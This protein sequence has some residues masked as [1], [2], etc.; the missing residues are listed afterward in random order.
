MRYDMQVKEEKI[1]E[2]FNRVIQYYP[3]NIRKSYWGNVD[4]FINLITDYEEKEDS[5]S[6]GCKNSAIIEFPKAIFKFLFAGD[7][8]YT[9][10]N[11]IGKRYEY[12]DFIFIEFVES[13]NVAIN[14]TDKAGLFSITKNQKGNTE[15]CFF[16]KA[17]NSDDNYYDYPEEIIP[18]F[19]SQMKSRLK[20]SGDTLP[21]NFLDHFEPM[22]YVL[23]VKKD[24]EFLLTKLIYKL[25]TNLGVVENIVKEKEQFIKVSNGLETLLDDD[26]NIII[27]NEQEEN[28]N[29]L[30]FYVSAIKNPNPYYCFLDA[31]HIFESLFYKYFYDYVKNSNSSQNKNE[32]YN[33]IKKHTNEEQMLKLVLMNCLDTKDLGEIKKS[34]IDREIQ[35]LV[36]R[37]GISKDIKK[38]D[39]LEENNFEN[40]ALHLS[41]LIYGF[42]N[43][44][45]HSTRADRHIEKIEEDPDLTPQFIDLTN[46]VLELA[47]RIIEKNIKNW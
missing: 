22:K 26:G 2:F 3:E 38:F 43:A 20:I 42:R 23:R 17:E 25:A 37:I 28:I 8:S 46:I 44:I 36:D 12:E 30:N 7:N 16:I 10:D 39:N 34:L 29:L 27:T 6:V 4:D 11:L 21:S 32:L 47:K 1:K 45:V 31:Y 33:E 9:F 18:F 19:V 35:K 15:S 41:K 13:P 5:I 24:Q 40:F 14:K